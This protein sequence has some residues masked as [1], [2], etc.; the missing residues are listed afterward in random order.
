[1]ADEWENPERLLQAKTR[2][3]PGFIDVSQT[4]PVIYYRERMTLNDY[5]VTSYAS[6]FLTGTCVKKKLFGD[7][8]NE[9]I[10]VVYTI[11]ILK[12]SDLLHDIFNECCRINHEKPHGIYAHGRPTDEQLVE[13]N[14][15]YHDNQ[16]DTR[17]GFDG[18]TYVQEA[19]SVEP[20]PR[21]CFFLNISNKSDHIADEVMKYIICYYLLKLDIPSFNDNFRI[22]NI[23]TRSL[24]RYYPISVESR[25]NRVMWVT[26]LEGV[27]DGKNI[28]RLRVHEIHKSF[29]Q[30]RSEDVKSIF[31]NKFG[32]S[33]L[34]T[35]VKM[36]DADINDDNRATHNLAMYL[37]TAPIAGVTAN[38]LPTAETDKNLI[39]ALWLADKLH[40]NQHGRLI[41][42]EEFSDAEI[43]QVFSY[44]KITIIFF[45]SSAFRSLLSFFN[46]NELDGTV[47][48]GM[49]INQIRFFCA[50]KSKSA[51][52]A[53]IKP[54]IDRLGGLESPQK[55][56]LFQLIFTFRMIKY[57]TILVVGVTAYEP[58]IL[59]F[60]IETGRLVYPDLYT[61]VAPG[62][63]ITR[64]RPDGSYAI[65][66][67]ANSIPP[68][69]PN[70]NLVC[71][72]TLIDGGATP[73]PPNC[74]FL[75]KK[76]ISFEHLHGSVNIE[77]PTTN[78]RVSFMKD[79]TLITA[80]Y[81]FDPYHKQHNKTILREELQARKFNHAAPDFFDI[82][83]KGL[84]DWLQY[85]CLAQFTPGEIHESPVPGT[86]TV[87]QNDIMSAILMKIYQST[88][89]FSA[90]VQNALWCPTRKF[91]TGNLN[92]HFLYTSQC[93][94]DTRMKGGDIT[95]NEK[96]IEYDKDT[97]KLM[98]HFLTIIALVIEAA[99]IDQR[100]RLIPSDIAL[101]H[102]FLDYDDVV[103]QLHEDYDISR[104]QLLGII[105]YYPLDE[106]YALEAID[107]DRHRGVSHIPLNPIYIEI[108]KNAFSRPVCPIGTNDIVYYTS[109]LHDSFI[110]TPGSRELRAVEEGELLANTSGYNAALSARHLSE[111][112]LEA[113][114]TEI[115]KEWQDSLKDI[116]I[117]IAGEAA[118]QGVRYAAAQVRGMPEGWHHT[119]EGLPAKVAQN[120]IEKSVIK[121]EGLKSP[122][123]KELLTQ[124]VGKIAAQAA[125]EATLNAVESI[126]QSL[127]QQAHTAAQAQ[128]SLAPLQPL[129]TVSQNVSPRRPGAAANSGF[130]T[131]IRFARGFE[132]QG[133]PQG[134]AAKSVK[135]KKNR[136]VSHDNLRALIKKVSMKKASMKKASMN[137]PMKELMKK[138]SMNGPMKELMKGQYEVLMKK[139]SK[140]GGTNTRNKTIKT[141]L[142]T[143]NKT[144]K[145]TIKKTIKNKK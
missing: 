42:Y 35:I 48:D 2:E 139:A 55:F 131:P 16:Y 5:P 103:T 144:F 39:H 109:L 68:G 133:S 19:S 23:I 93:L 46:I 56:A 98:Q 143:K 114:A 94:I 36:T 63:I 106:L 82:C 111:K 38:I 54:H 50:N 101:I 124:S 8:R 43:N 73:D 60:F 121:I 116:A 40:D 11:D 142:K 53:F 66:N 125:G 134:A 6:E 45:L 17:L 3:G 44:L 84:C 83:K 58:H 127:A 27:L 78:I 1:M 126:G 91:L 15:Y 4:P 47:L 22:D 20:V 129:S 69:N 88:Y 92:S 62:V 100:I 61:Q 67:A 80:P 12:S 57:F 110:H 113:Q 33:N 118:E 108:S 136:T 65:N 70:S 32:H 132:E 86:V 14:Q 140:K 7:S 89:E 29:D 28:Y 64:S 122:E 145:K 41:R 26:L 72:G 119:L 18:T 76:N 137:G 128:A 75:S 96:E 115:P 117:E 25:T 135:F 141:K 37:T 71:Y 95:D 81:E 34:D 49:S 30:V 74:F 107:T 9:K 24:R 77:Y 87:F 21:P 138:V 120:A 123:L 105:E 99:K 52:L 13:I 112:Y 51:F 10:E 97:N 85:S 79:G 104:E 59:T 90:H 130:G 102:F 31:E